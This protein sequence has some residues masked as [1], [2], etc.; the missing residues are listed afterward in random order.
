[1]AAPHKRCFTDE[2]LCWVLPPTA[3]RRRWSF[4][5]DFCDINRYAVL[6]V[7]GRRRQCIP[8]RDTALTVAVIEAALERRKT[9]A[10]W[11]SLLLLLPLPMRPRTSA[12]GGS[13]A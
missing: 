8:D 9:C 1:M 6:L 3:G 10:R 12:G 13:F 11:Q 5:T 2:A 4:S 7:A